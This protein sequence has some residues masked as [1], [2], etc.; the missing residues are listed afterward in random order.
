MT[1]SVKVVIFQILFFFP[2]LGYRGQTA[3]ANFF[4]FDMIDLG[5]LESISSNFY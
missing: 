4:K 1:I 2:F 5:I 3:T